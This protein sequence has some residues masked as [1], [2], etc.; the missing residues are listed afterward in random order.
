M[1]VLFFKFSNSNEFMFVM[2]RN[3]HEDEPE[4]M[5]TKFPQKALPNLVTENV[6]LVPESG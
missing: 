5:P 6:D 3:G 2:D 1:F 4:A